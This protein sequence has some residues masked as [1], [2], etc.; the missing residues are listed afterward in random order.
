MEKRGGRRKLLHMPSCSPVKLEC[1]WIHNAHTNNSLLRP[2]SIGAYC[3]QAAEHTDCTKHWVSVCA[4]LSCIKS[5]GKKDLQQPLALLGAVCLS[6]AN[7]LWFLRQP[8]VNLMVLFLLSLKPKGEQTHK[9]PQIFRGEISF[10]VP[11][12]HM[13]VVTLL[14]GTRNLWRGFWSLLFLMWG[15]ISAR[16]LWILNQTIHVTL[17]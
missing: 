12:N 11:W 4:V 7:G 15:Y 9:I 3:A 6:P 1:E 17:M 13:K 5:W 16:H 8:Q 14:S 2:F 10:N